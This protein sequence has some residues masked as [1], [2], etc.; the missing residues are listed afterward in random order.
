MIQVKM[1]KH[2]Q[3]HTIKNIEMFFAPETQWGKIS[4]DAYLASVFAAEHSKLI[5]HGVAV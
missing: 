1:S 5:F 2:T 3:T 4:T